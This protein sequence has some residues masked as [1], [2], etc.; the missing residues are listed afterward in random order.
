ML[1]HIKRTIKALSEKNLPPVFIFAYD[2]LWNLQYQMNGFLKI[3][4]CRLP[5]TT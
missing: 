5:S 2:E 4:R 1:D 3:I